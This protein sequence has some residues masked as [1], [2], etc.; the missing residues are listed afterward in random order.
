M[1]DEMKAWITFK[2]SG[3]IWDYIAYCDTVKENRHD[4]V[5][6]RADFEGNKTQRK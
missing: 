5:Y 3:A 1:H 6:M 4:L 2:E